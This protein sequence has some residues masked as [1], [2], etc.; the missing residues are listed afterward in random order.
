MGVRGK[1]KKIVETYGL[2]WELAKLFGKP[3]GLLLKELTQREIK[4]YAA[5]YNWSEW[6]TK[7]THYYLMQ[8]AMEIRLLRME[9]AGR[10]GSVKLSDFDLTAKEQGG[11]HVDSVAEAK[12][13]WL[14]ALGM[15]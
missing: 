12:E 9:M 1:R 7:L 8:I 5:L 6:R 15:K 11:R 4:A 2:Y 3:V 13:F 14:T 10:S